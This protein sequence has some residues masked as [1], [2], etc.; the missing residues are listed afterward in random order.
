[1]ARLSTFPTPPPA[2]IAHPITNAKPII[3]RACGFR[4]CS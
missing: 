2:V 1:M 4:S 3:M